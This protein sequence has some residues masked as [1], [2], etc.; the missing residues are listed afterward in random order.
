MALLPPLLGCVLDNIVVELEEEEMVCWNA[1]SLEI[2]DPGELDNVGV[3]IGEGGI[4]DGDPD[5]DE[6]EEVNIGVNCDCV[7]EAI[8]R[9]GIDDK[10]SGGNVCEAVVCAGDGAGLVVRTALFAQGLLFVGIKSGGDGGGDGFKISTVDWEAEGK[11]EGNGEGEGEDEGEG[12]IRC[13]FDGAEEE[14]VEF[15][16]IGYGTVEVEEEDDA[17]VETGWDGASSTI[18][19]CCLLLLVLSSVRSVAAAVEE[20]FVC[21]SQFGIDEMSESNERSDR[22]MWRLM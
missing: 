7:L 14:E 12:E 4:R 19:T 3:Y 15:V 20:M 1:G 10:G 9:V 21:I 13:R 8:G 5:K 17:S 11:G 2:N 18:S 6:E 22:T 16:T